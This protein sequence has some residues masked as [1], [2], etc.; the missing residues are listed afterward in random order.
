MKSPA[1]IALLM[2]M[3]LAPS[4]PQVRADAVTDWNANAEAVLRGAP[5]SPPLQLRALAIVNSAIYDA[6]NGIAQ[7]YEPYLITVQAPP[8]A[9]EEAAAIS[10]AHT[11]LTGLY[12]AQS[13]FLN[14]KLAESTAKIP[15]IQ[16]NSRSIARGLAWGK[17]VGL[18]V[19]ASRAN[20]GIN[21]SVPPYLGGFA[22]GQ[23]RSI[24][25][26]TTPGALPQFASLTPFTLTSPSQF[27]P[28][29]PPSLTSAQYATDFNEVKSLGRVD[30][31]TR[32]ADQTKAALLWAATGPLEENAVIRSVVPA[33]YELVDTAR[34]FA[35]VNFAGCD[36]AIAGF[37]TKYTYG[38]W[39]PFHAIRFADTDGNPDTDVDATWT[40]LVTPVPNHPEYISTHS[41]ITGAEMRTLALIVGDI[42]F[43]L[44]SP[45]LP[46]VTIDYASFSVAAAEVGPARIWGGLHFRNSCV[47]GAAM[48]VQIGN[49]AV[50]NFLRP[51]E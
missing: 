10:A 42:P 33:D 44:S 39:R 26:G 45:G 8:G 16:G 38:F 12:P 50:S 18:A 6:V 48:G 28:G 30:S 21:A 13:A 1:V 19:L 14:D 17:Q 51:I 37:D 9:R 5:P 46:G 31:V 23:W 4:Q 25:N 27:R 2:A 3:A 41:I 24:P 43:T 11:V 34:L 20:D 40:S 49:Q 47:T 35:L 36:A 29:P 7:K 15:G 32:T 22:P